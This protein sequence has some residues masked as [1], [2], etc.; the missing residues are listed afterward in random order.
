MRH[1]LK[2][3]FNDSVVISGQS[4]KVVSTDECQKDAEKSISNLSQISVQNEIK[5]LMEKLNMTSN[6]VA[7]IK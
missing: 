2:L 6:E 7:S 3:K 5:N 4:E 1:R